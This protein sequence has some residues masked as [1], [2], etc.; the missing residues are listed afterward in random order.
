VEVVCHHPDHSASFAELSDFDVL[1]VV[2]TWA[3][4][5]AELGRRRHIEDVLV[6]ERCTPAQGAH[7]HSRL[8]AV[9]LVHALTQRE[10][11]AARRYQR[12]TGGLLGE[13]VLER[14]L[15]S[16]RTVTGNEHFAASVPW[17]ARRACEVLVLPR[18]PA[19]GLGDLDSERR[20]AL[21][22]LLREV[23]IRY[24][25]LWRG[26][27]PYLM[28]VHQAPRTREDVSCYPFHVELLPGLERP[29]DAR[30]GPAEP[31]SG[32][33]SPDEDAAALR[34]VPARLRREPS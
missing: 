20:L 1:A 8:Y 10:L 30:G 22:T 7:P 4:R 32:S 9:E 6:L 29:G 11:E 31:L 26:R 15:A 27:V 23:A 2:E 25:N 3:E 33:G 19:A 24:E 18:A 28:S 12:A 16:G 17:F 14:E 21:A 13:A 34:A 5:C